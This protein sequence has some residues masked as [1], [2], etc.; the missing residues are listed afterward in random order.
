[1]AGVGVLS[2][3]LSWKIEVSKVPRHPARP[4][5]AEGDLGAEADAASSLPLPL[6]AGL[7]EDAQSRAQFHSYDTS[8][9]R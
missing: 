3:A 5:A 6:G 8:P 9:Q 2:L 4:R 1:M 7:G